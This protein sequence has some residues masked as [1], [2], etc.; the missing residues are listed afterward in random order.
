MLLFFY[1]K[2]VAVRYIGMT[3]L[4]SD[5][6]THAVV[7]FP[8]EILTATGNYG[9]KVFDQQLNKE[10]APVITSRVVDNKKL[11]IQFTLAVTQRRFYTITIYNL[12]DGTTEYFR[13]VAFAADT[14][15]ALTKYSMYYEQLTL[16]AAN[17]NT[18]ITI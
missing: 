11:T 2:N 14:D 17:D 6:S 4:D 9:I 15:Q 16:P 7:C 5:V 13:G 18:Y 3:I 1:D 8:R 10:L 12:V